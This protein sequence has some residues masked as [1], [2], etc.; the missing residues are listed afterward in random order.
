MK[1]SI[2][3]LKAKIETLQNQYGRNYAIQDNAKKALFASIVI[4][5]CAVG[6]FVP[7][8]DIL[9]EEDAFLAA[10][11]LGESNLKG[12]YNL[13]FNT[14]F[15]ETKTT[16]EVSAY[17]WRIEQGQGDYNAYLNT[18][19]DGANIAKFIENNLDDVQTM[20]S[21][22]VAD[23]EPVDLE[24]KR[25]LQAQLDELVE[26][27]RVAEEFQKMEYLKEGIEF[28]EHTRINLK[29]DWLPNI[30][31]IKVLSETAKKVSIE[32]KTWWNETTPN[33]EKLCNK[34]NIIEAAFEWDFVEVEQQPA[35]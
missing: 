12:N 9:R 10:C 7:G 15:D 2:T 4:D 22:C 30:K 3:Q 27:E 29:S 1:L 31:E 19:I 25:Y 14:S 33:T 32:Y 17:S 6:N 20:L 23:V 35:A 16:V 18:I 24:Y 5:N 13:Y 8:G 34:Q 28:E 26:A 21:T 11:D